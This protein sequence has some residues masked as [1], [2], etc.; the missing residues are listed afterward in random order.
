MAVSEGVDGRRGRRNSPS[1]LNVA[2]SKSL[3]FDGRS[4][5]LEDQAWEPILAEDEMGNASEADV[6]KRLGASARYRDLFD[7]AFGDEAPNK[8]GVA[9]ALLEQLLTSSPP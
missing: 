6:L 5:T 4:E 7:R 1:L 8:E 2:Y 9:Q 3:F